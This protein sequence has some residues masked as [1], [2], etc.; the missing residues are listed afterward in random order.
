[1]ELN[2]R[3]IRGYLA[4]SKFMKVITWVLQIVITIALAAVISLMFCQTVALQEGSMD[5]TFSAGEKFLINRAVYKIGSPQRG[6]VI[7][8]R[9]S[10]DKKGSTHIKRVIGIPGDTIQIKDGQ[11]RINDKTY[12]EERDLPSIVNAGIAEDPIVLESD[13]YFVLGDNRNNSEDSRFADIGNVKKEN[14][15]GKIWFVISPMNRIGF[16]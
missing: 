14:I 5:P 13:E 4:Q 9:I 16:V 7:A 6:D 8:F 1:M 11:I 15:I 10:S 3:Y 2:F 12:V